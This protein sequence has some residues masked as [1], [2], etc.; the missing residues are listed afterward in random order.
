MAIVYAGVQKGIERGSKIMMPLLLV[1][2]IILMIKGLSLPG[3]EKGVAFLLEPNWD[4]VT[5]ETVLLALGHAFF[6][7]S[8]GMGA[9]MT[10][11]SYMKKKDSILSSS[12]QIIFLDTIIALI[13]GVAIFTAV[14]ATGQNP[15]E[16]PGLI[17]VTLPVVFTKMT[18]GYIFSILFFLL[19]S[20]AALTSSIS[21]LEVVIAY[22]VDEKKW[23]RKRTVLVFGGITFLVAIP[24][25][26][27]FNLLSDVTFFGLNFFGIADYLA[28][29]ILLPFG[30][31]FI[32]IF[33]AWIWGFDKVLIELK[34]G[35]ERIFEKHAWVISAW[36]I[37]IKYF[38][39]VLIFFVLLSKLG[40]LDLI[41]KNK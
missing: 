2:L 11:G 4:N 26:L 13:A 18:G 35:S 16:G 40:I 8:L 10:Y 25:A 20:I 30:G 6:T 19:L 32:S 33:V 37:F 29:N 7:L 22:Y 34:K 38:A 17:F 1:I 9:M 41:F 31:F 21:L 27:S 12:V 24:S 5:G 28:S 23:N 36:K 3:A 15:S 39:P 14:F